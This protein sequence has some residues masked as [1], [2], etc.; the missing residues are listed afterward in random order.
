MWLME[1]VLWQQTFIFGGQS[2]HG[3]NNKDSAFELDENSPRVLILY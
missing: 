1:K 2:L 3:C